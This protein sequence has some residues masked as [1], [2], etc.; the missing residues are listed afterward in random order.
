MKVSAGVPAS[1]VSATAPLAWPSRFMNRPSSGVAMTSGSPVVIQC[2]AALAATASSSG[3]VAHQ[4]QVE[5]AVLVVGGEQ[6]VERQQRGEQRAEPE[7]RRADAAEQGEVGPDRERASA[8]PRSGRTARRC[9]APPPTRIA[10][11]MSRMNSASERAHAASP[12]RSS[13]A[14]SSP[15]GP[16]AAATISPPPARCCRIRPASASCASR[17]SAEVGSSSSQIGRG[18]ATSRAMRQPP[19]LAGRQVGGRQV[20][21]RRQP[22][23]GQRRLGAAPRRRDSGPRM[24]GFPRPSGRASARPGGRGNGPAPG[25]SCRGRRRPAPARPPAIRSR[26]ANIRS[27]EDLP[28]P[29]R[30]VTSRAS[31]PPTGQNPAP[32]T[33][34]GRPG[35][36]PG[37]CLKPHRARPAVRTPDM[38]ATQSPSFELFSFV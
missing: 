10:S 6:P 2:A 33:P 8:R 34:R 30:P 37:R 31:P 17:S 35:R 29:L 11:R 1:S 12:S 19:P 38:P 36:R 28:A 9:R 14:R 27:S 23:G 13:L 24:R 15:I 20:G 32:K 26:P 21:Q 5:R 25:W 16:C 4:H 3:V 18:T 7:D 22:D